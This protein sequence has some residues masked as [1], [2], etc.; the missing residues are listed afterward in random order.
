M[1]KQLVQ[2][3]TLES[4]DIH[5]TVEIKATEYGIKIELNSAV[6]AQYGTNIKKIM[7]EIITKAGVTEG[8]HIVA[9]DKGALSC[10]IEARTKTALMRLGLLGGTQ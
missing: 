10:T 1:S 2:A 9:N 7:H 6:F 4:N 8:L 5:I 3:G